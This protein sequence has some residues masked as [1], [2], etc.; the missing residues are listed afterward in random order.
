MPDLPQVARTLRSQKYQSQRCLELQAQLHCLQVATARTARLSKIARSIRHTLAEC[1]RCEDKPSFVSLFNAFQDAAED[2]SKV[3]V[4]AIQEVLDASLASRGIPTSFLDGLPPSSSAAI[5]NLLT[6]LRYDG[7]YISDRFA[8]LS[9]EELL[10]LIPRRTST[11]PAES[12]FGYSAG[13]SSRTSRYLGYI[14]DGQTELLSSHRFGSPL[15]TMIHGVQAFPLDRVDEDGRSLDV[16]SSVCARLLAGQRPG[17]EKLV[18]AVLDI[19]ASFGPWPGR[20]RLAEHISQLLQ[21]GAFLLE[22]P[23]KQS[24][25]MRI[26]VRPAPNE[27]EMRAESFYAGAVAGLLELLGDVSAASVIPESVIQMFKAIWKKLPPGSSYQRGFS[28]FVLT[29]WLLSTFVHEALI[30]PEVR[31]SHMLY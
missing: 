7:D 23:S 3:T 15:E 11:R 16:W 27:E 24:F 20:R 31:T 29:R 9:Q 4:P 17:S 21:R 19:W 28:R 26:E 1:I 22:Q 2:C 30:C 14:V 13:P 25:R 8:V 18:P 12:V 10:A 6:R 5:V